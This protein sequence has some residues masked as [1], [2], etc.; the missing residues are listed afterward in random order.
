LA[1]LL[2]IGLDRV[3]ASLPHHEFSCE[4]SAPHFCFAAVTAPSCFTDWLMEPYA[5]ATGRVQNRGP[6]GVVFA[7][8]ACEAPATLSRGNAQRRQWGR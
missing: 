3:E 7:K 2:G 1:T 8:P 6:G 4:T 5:R